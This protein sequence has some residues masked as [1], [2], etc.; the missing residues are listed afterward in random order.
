[1][2]LKHGGELEIGDLIGVSYTSGFY[3]GIFAGYGRGTIQYYMPQGVI[4]GAEHFAKNNKKPKFYKAY[5][6]GDNVEYRVL[7]LNKDVLYKQK[8]LQQYEQAID[9]LKQENIIK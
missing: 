3:I 9:I 2:R 7:K 4:F 8:D 6:Y 1:M 5:V